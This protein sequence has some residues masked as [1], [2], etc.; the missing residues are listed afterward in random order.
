LHFN[1]FLITPYFTSGQN[2]VQGFTPISDILEQ[3]AKAVS[4]PSLEDVIIDL[5][6][7]RGGAVF[8]LSI[9]WAHIL[10][11]RD[12]PAGYNRMKIGDGRLDY[13]PRIPFNITNSYVEETFAYRGINIPPRNPRPVT[14]PIVVLADLNSISCA[15]ISTIALSNLPNGYFVGETTWGGQGQLI[16]NNNT[17]IMYNAGQF[18]NSFFDMV[19]TPFVIFE[20]VDGKCY[21]GKGYS[22]KNAP[23]GYEVKYNKAAIQTGNDPQLEKAIEVIITNSK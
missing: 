1:G 21:E 17:H 16:E 13:G 15:E 9:L 8:D 4:N 23:R 7:N 3:F 5:R 20:A 6:G 18:N 2:D 10:M 19:Y 22:P 11:G 12:L 14:V